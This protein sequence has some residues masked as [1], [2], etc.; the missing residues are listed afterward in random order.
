MGCA[1]SAPGNTCRRPRLH[2]VVDEH[3]LI[4]NATRAALLLVGYGEQDLLGHFLGLIMSPFVSFLHR[5]FFLPKYRCTS[6]IDRYKLELYLAAKSVRRPMVIYVRTVVSAPA[7]TH[8][9]PPPIPQDSHR[10]SHL[11]TISVRPS[12]QSCVEDFVRPYVSSSTFL[13]CSFE[14]IDSSLVVWNLEQ[15]SLRLL[16][17]V[18]DRDEM[19]VSTVKS[20]II[21]MW[22]A[23]ADM[24]TELASFMDQVI[25]D[26]YYPYL[27]IYQRISA[28]GDGVECVF[29]VST[30]FTYS[31][32]LFAV[33]LA[34]KFVSDVHTRFPLTSVGLAYGT[35]LYG[36]QHER[37]VIMGKTITDAGRLSL[38]ASHVALTRAAHEKFRGEYRLITNADPDAHFLQDKIP[39]DQVC[40]LMSPG[41]RL[42]GPDQRASP[43][44]L[45]QVTLVF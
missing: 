11:V 22:W 23:A 39:L 6:G 12:P 30:E 21:R 2:L 4:V 9:N 29:I 19:H 1:T 3:G 17:K 13:L 24:A 31:M 26:Q 14:P 42:F 36:F 25:S 15:P 16:L 20:V 28:D 45:S 33:L 35:T 40:L 8:S 34:L 32:D 18:N 5:S 7:P 37:F 27:Y 41:A 38:T 10:G 43:A 44:A